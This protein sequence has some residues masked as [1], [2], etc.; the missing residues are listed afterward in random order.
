MAKNSKKFYCASYT[1]GE[2]V[3][4]VSEHV[5]THLKPQT[6]EEFGHYLAGLIDGDGSFGERRLNIVFNK[7]DASLAYYIKGRLGHGTV[8]K[9]KDKNAVVFLCNKSRRVR[10][11]YK[12][13]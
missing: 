5:P 3:K 1:G 9:I 13:N 8:R 10:E 2:N 11:S 12:F 7:L 6:D 4:L